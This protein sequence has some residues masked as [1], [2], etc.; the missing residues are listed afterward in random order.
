MQQGNN[1]IKEVQFSNAELLPEIVKMMDEGHTVTLRLRGYSMRPFLEDNRDKAL[2]AKAKDLKKGDVVLAEIEPKHF[3]L[4]RVIK[5]SEDGVTLRGDG[6]L[7]VEH[8]TK[9][10]VRGFVI[11]FYRKGREK[12]DKTNGL[13]WRL[14]SLVW[15]ALYPVRRYLLAAYRRIWLR[16]FKPI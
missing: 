1:E 8:C 3:V 9:E 10:D 5:I 13:K 16:F 4:H 14:Y 15:G 7:G 12:I 2:M 11:G 6:N